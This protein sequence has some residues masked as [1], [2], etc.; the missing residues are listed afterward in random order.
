MQDWYQKI[1]A[2]L[3]KQKWSKLYDQHTNNMV[4]DGSVS[5][6]LNSH[7]YSDILNHVAKDIEKVIL[8]KEHLRGDGVGLIQDLISQNDPKFNTITRIS[9]KSE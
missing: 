8:A 7:L 5:P 1:L 3:A 4:L 2:L 6:K 9:K